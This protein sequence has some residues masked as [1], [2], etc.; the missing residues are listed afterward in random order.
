ML[1]SLCVCV[2]P[3]IHRLGLAKNYARLYACRHGLVTMWML[4]I[5]EQHSGTFT[6]SYDSYA[7]VV[8]LYI[9]I[10]Y[11][12]CSAH[13]HINCWY[14]WVCSHIASSCCCFD[15]IACT[16]LCSCS[17]FMWWLHPIPMHPNAVHDCMDGS[18][19]AQSGCRRMAFK[20][21]AQF[22][23]ARPTPTHTHTALSASPW[24][25]MQQIHWHC[26]TQNGRMVYPKSI[27][28]GI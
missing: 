11:I 26:T 12:Q 20:Y 16:A 7:I 17:S 2:S 13:R 5:C 28:T 1:S 3:P 9:Y 4:Q 15:R 27:E 22:S 14:R 23:G 10:V 8:A 25:A 19:W 21:I 18:A 6:I 24:K